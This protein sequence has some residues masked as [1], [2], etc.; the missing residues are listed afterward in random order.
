MCIAVMSAS[1]AQIARVCVLNCC[2]CIAEKREKNME[3][4]MKMKMK[5]MLNFTNK[6]ENQLDKRKLFETFSRVY[7]SLQQ[8]VRTCVFCTCCNDWMLKAFNLK[9]NQKACKPEIS[10]A[11]FAHVNSEVKCSVFKYAS[12][13][14]TRIY[15]IYVYMREHET[16][17]Q[18]TKYYHIFRQIILLCM[19]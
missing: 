14:T 19:Q 16:S 7:N 8:C 1:F 17:A 11:T 6:G 9:H 3:K 4:V 10:Q 18:Y 2:V 12:K 13:G 5:F 15:M